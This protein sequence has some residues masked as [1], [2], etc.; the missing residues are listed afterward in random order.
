MKLVSESKVRKVFMQQ[1]IEFDKA[2]ILAMDVI[3]MFLDGKNDHLDLDTVV[4]QLIERELAKVA[5]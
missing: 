2:H 3:N 1:D 4:S 5:A